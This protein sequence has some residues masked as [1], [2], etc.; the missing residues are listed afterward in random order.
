MQ[1][2][3]NAHCRS[4]SMRKKMACSILAQNKRIGETSRK[5]RSYG[6][7]PS[8]D[9]TE[10][11]NQLGTEP[12]TINMQGRALL[13]GS[14]GRLLAKKRNEAKEKRQRERRGGRQRA[15]ERREKAGRTQEQEW[16]V[17]DLG[18]HGLENEVAWIGVN[19]ISWPGCALC[20]K[21]FSVLLVMLLMWR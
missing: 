15:E 13:E 11:A 21:V 12:R 9:A 4:E 5:E 10:E 8:R 16:S 7:A 1:L 19:K 2:Q 17:F 3:R 18:L 6:V 20:L 14:Y